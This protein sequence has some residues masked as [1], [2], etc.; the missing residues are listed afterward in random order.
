MTDEPIPP[1]PEYLA[2][3]TPIGEPESLETEIE[4]PQPILTGCIDMNAL[5]D[6]AIAEEAAA[7]KGKKTPPPPPPA[8]I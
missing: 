8:E 2:T 7:Q 4:Q 5:H 6:E 1:T 3:L